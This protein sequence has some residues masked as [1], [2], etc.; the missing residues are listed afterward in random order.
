MIQSDLT[1]IVFH[2]MTEWERIST[3]EMFTQEQKTETIFLAF[4]EGELDISSLQL[5][6]QN[7][8]ISQEIV[9]EIIYDFLNWCAKKLTEE[10]QK[11][12]DENPRFEDIRML[13]LRL[14][15]YQKMFKEE[16]YKYS[17]RKKYE[18]L[19]PQAEIVSEA[20]RKLSCLE[21]K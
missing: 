11:V 21:R 13:K 2:K 1:V 7:N 16:I 10:C 3:Q 18:G 17:L 20:F 15:L 4:V 5:L 14:K 9:D 12:I 6:V 19:F 8:L